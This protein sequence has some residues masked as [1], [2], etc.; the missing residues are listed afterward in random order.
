LGGGVG[1]DAWLV[2][3][4]RCELARDRFDLAC[5]LA[6]LGDQLQDASGDRAQREQRAAEFWIAS[7]VRSRCR[8]AFQQ[9]RGCQ[10]PQLAA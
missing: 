10:R 9:P 5:E 4:L 7:I 8:E 6:L 2:E 3:Q 1:S